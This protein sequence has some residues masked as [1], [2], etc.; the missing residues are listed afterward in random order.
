MNCYLLG[1]WDQGAN[2]VAYTTEDSLVNLH[3]DLA[4]ARKT[5]QAVL[6]LAYLAAADGAAKGGVYGRSAI[7]DV[8]GPF[9]DV[10]RYSPFDT[11]HWF[12]NAAAGHIVP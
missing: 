5:R 9:N 11:V 6:G 8:P 7:H 3:S 2:R 12:K 1:K 10:T 4:P